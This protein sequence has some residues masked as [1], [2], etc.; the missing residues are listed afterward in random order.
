AVAHRPSRDSVSL[1][2]G[3]ANTPRSA[4][5][6]P[7]IGR[8][9]A[10]YRPDGPTDLKLFANPGWAR[11]AQRGS[12]PDVEAGRIALTRVPGC[13]ARDLAALGGGPDLWG[14]SRASLMP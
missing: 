12:A 6:R 9:S 8:I 2:R 5:T 11:T 14:M 4:L 13:S 3:P 10:A 1:G 7:R